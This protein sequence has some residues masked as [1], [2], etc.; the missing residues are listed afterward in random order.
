L[1]HGADVQGFLDFNKIFSKKDLTRKKKYG[2]KL[3]YY[4]GF[5]FYSKITRLCEGL[6]LM[7]TNSQVLANA[8]KRQNCL[9]Q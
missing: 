7:D 4:F 1:P 3:K 9:Q 6:V 2:W 5:L 8:N